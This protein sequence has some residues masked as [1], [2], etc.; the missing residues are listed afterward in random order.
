MN[1]PS[2]FAKKR[3]RKNI[4]QICGMKAR[5]RFG[6]LK[7][8]R[9]RLRALVV[10]ECIQCHRVLPFFS[11]PLT[12]SIA[13]RPSDYHCNTALCLFYTHRNLSYRVGANPEKLVSQLP[14]N[15]ILA[16]F[17]LIEC[18][19]SRGHIECLSPQILQSLARLSLVACVYAA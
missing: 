4:S 7:K 17:S 18:V 3:E 16:I 14:E 13:R 9:H 19:V 1:A 6:G 15:L 11:S 10:F 5:S 8:F 2:L 12:P